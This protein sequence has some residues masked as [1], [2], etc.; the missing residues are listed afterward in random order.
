MSFDNMDEMFGG[1]VLEATAVTQKGGEIKPLEEGFYEA[2]CAAVV[3]RTMEVTGQDPKQVIE[4]VWQV[5]DGTEVHYLRS[6]SLTSLKLN[7]EK[8]NFYVIMKGIAKLTG[9][10]DPTITSK[11]E[12]LKV[13]RDGF[14]RPKYLL[15]LSCRVSV[16]QETNTKGKTYSKIV[17]YSPSKLEDNTVKTGT[18]PDS[19]LNWDGGSV[20]Q[21]AE[22]LVATFKTEKPLAPSIQGV[23]KSNTSTVVTADTFA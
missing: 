9:P 16:I 19:L 21:L 20:Y 15:G 13:S 23:G 7:N 8:S 22:G 1:S 18:V 4:L 6:K 12:A 2:V 3:M 5:V 11:M 14:L 17:S 10:T